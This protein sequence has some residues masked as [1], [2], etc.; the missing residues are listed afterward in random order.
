MTTYLEAYDVALTWSA[1]RKV[2]VLRRYA[3]R[4]LGLMAAWA[5]SLIKI[6]DGEL[7]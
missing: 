2:S 6:D 7:G 3:L 4:Y 5:F 1:R